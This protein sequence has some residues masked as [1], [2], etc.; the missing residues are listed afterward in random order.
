MADKPRPTPPGLWKPG[1]SGN[2]RG[3]NKGPS[4]TR[5]F[6]ETLSKTALLGKDLPPGMNVAE[7][8]VEACF[9]HAIQGNGIY[10]KEITTRLEGIVTQEAASGKTT[11]DAPRKRIDLLDRRSALPNGEPPTDAGDRS[12]DATE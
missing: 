7:L 2:P 8:F 11:D 1:Q 4:L 6:R 5:L 10:A 3:R 12:G 9:A